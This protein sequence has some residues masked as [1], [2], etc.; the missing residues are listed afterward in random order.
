M[1]FTFHYYFIQEILIYKLRNRGTIQPSL[2]FLYIYTYM[3]ILVWTHTDSDVLVDRIWHQSL[4]HRIHCMWY[5]DLTHDGLS[6]LA[7]VS[8]GGVHIL[9]VELIVVI[10]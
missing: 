4:A 3:I 8:T 7:I 5:G 6:E 2:D 10:Q 9:Q 1:L